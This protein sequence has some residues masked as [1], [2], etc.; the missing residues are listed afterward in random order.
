MKMA[1]GTGQT[2]SESTYQILSSMIFSRKLPG[3]KVIEERPLSEELNISRT[4][5][6]YALSRLHGEG[7]LERLSNGLYMVPVPTIEEYMDLVQLRRILEGAAAALAAGRMDPTKLGDLRVR[8][9]SMMAQD[10]VDVAG[11]FLIDDDLHMAIA[12]ASGNAALH[13]TIDS[14]RRQ[15]RMCNV[16]RYPG[17]FK[18]TCAEHLAILDAI[19]AGDAEGARAALDEHLD[20]VWEGFVS[21]L[22]KR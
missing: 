8:F 15:V 12:E 4:P 6:R 21:N 7:M 13:R 3:G 10:D 20:K 5:L 16:K 18:E 19:G 22:S 9:E 1:D 2:L 14:V 17:R 11:H